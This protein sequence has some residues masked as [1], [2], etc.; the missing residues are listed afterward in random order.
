MEG[1]SKDNEDN[2]G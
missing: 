2:T 1:P